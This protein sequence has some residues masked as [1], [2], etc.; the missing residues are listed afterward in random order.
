MFNTWLDTFI[1][2][3]GIDTEK[4]FDIEGPSGLNVIPVGVIIEHMKITSPKEQAA[5][6]NM[7]VKIDFHNGDVLDFFKHLAQAIA[8]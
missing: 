2:E 5:I 7:I 6:K 1:S 3:K 8:K 4:T